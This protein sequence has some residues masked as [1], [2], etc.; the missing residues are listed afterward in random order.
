VGK[1]EAILSG[2]LSFIFNSFGPELRFVDAVKEA[3][4]LG[5]TEP[6]PRDDLSGADV[7]RKILILAREVGVGLEPRDVEVARLLPENC[8]AAPTVDAFFAELEASDSYFAELL[9]SA[10]EN[11]EKLRYIATLEHGKA[12]VEL[13]T[14]GPGHPFYTLSGSD[15]IVSFTTER[16]KDRP[17]VIK[18]PGAGAEVTASGVFADIMSIGSYLS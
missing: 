5:F 13:K 12:T 11:G 16:Y 14:V 1:I 15:N 2:T 7:A 8:L 9:Q 17:L 3:K 4:A 6:D 18:G 10:E